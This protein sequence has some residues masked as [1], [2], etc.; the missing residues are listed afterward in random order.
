MPI[1]P[2]NRKRY[3]ANWK[4]ISETIRF[5]RAHGYCECGGECSVHQNL[6]NAKHGWP[7]PITG[8]SVV[9]TVAHL[10]HQPENN[11]FDNLKAMCQRCHLNYDLQHHKQSRLNAIRC[12]ETGDLFV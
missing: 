11:S 9:L 6:C 5:K 2:E 8:S 3:P 4:W 1:K 7:H 10:D 12:N